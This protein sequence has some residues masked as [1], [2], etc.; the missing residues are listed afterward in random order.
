MSSSGVE[1][2]PLC[3][4]SRVEVAEG[5]VA[6]EFIR[7]HHRISPP[8]AHAVPPTLHCERVTSCETKD[9]DA[10]ETTRLIVRRHSSITDSQMPSNSRKND[11][12]YNSG[13]TEFP[14]HD[15]HMPVDTSLNSY[16]LSLSLDLSVF[17][18]VLLTCGLNQ[19]THESERPLVEPS[20]QGFLW[21]SYS[22]RFL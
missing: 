18:G 9:A 21:L 7:D 4:A 14:S 8:S 3:A 11:R 17:T 2:G 13:I 20:V 15:P 5:T 19:L 22:E 6:A 12:S 16:A 10:D 1:S